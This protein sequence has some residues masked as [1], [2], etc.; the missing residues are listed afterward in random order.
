MDLVP[1]DTSLVLAG[2][3]AGRALPHPLWAGGGSSTYCKAH[4]TGGMCH[5]TRP[6]LEVSL[7][8]TPR[9]IVWPQL[10]QGVPR[11]LRL[12]AW[13]AGAAGEPLRGCSE[14]HNP[15]PPHEWQLSTQA[16]GG[17]EPAPAASLPWVITS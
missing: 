8:F 11:A 4:V 15:F 12:L 2:G 9:H 3:E 16:A 5:H 6:K 10:G 13:F 14:E 7:G 1:W 17:A